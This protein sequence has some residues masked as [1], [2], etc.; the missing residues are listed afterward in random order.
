MSNVLPFPADRLRHT[1]TP[2]SAT[3]YPKT[4][5]EILLFTG[6]RY[7][8]RPDDGSEARKPHPADK[9]RN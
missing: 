2:P 1:P 9:K 8:R 3:V 7:M 4:H 6:V 5:G